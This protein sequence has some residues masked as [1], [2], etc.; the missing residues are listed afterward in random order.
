MPM[1]QTWSCDIF[2]TQFL[3]LI[4]LAVAQMRMARADDIDYARTCE[5][6]SDPANLM[7]AYIASLLTQ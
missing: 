7:Y 2:A 6:Y 1:L 3:V 5:Y 4:T